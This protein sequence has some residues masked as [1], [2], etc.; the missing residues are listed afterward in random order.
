[1]LE[2]PERQVVNKIHPLRS[3][4]PR[5]RQAGISLAVDNFGRG[6]FCVNILDQ[7]PFGEIKI[8]PSIVA[9]CTASPENTK[10]CK[11]LVQ[12]THNFGCRAVAVG[13]SEAADLQA[14]RQLDCDMGQGF[15]SANR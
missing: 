11:T 7:I 5:L 10:I 8:D 12:V 6:S 13:V 3:R 2:I 4:A 14:S 1:M 9:G 15:C